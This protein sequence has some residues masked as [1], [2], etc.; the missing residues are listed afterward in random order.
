MLIHITYRNKQPGYLS[1]VLLPSRS[2]PLMAS[3]DISPCTMGDHRAEEDRIEPRKWAV[4]SSDQAPRQRK[5]DIAGVVDFASISIFKDTLVDVWVWNARLLT[6]PVT[7]Q[8]ISGRGCNR[9]RI[10]H[11]FPR[12]LGKGLAIQS[13]AY[14]LA[15]LTL[16][17]TILLAVARIPDPVNK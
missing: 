17:E 12:K 6:P 8:T 3:S 4:E 13:R 9:S 16:P 1:S 5:V 2:V 7:Q 14:A 15:S 10:L 11:L